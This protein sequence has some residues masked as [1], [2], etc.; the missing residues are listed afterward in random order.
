MEDLKEMM[1][2]LLDNQKTLIKN[3]D[4]LFA[5]MKEVRKDVKT[6]RVTYWK[7]MG[8]VIVTSILTVLS[9]FGIA[10]K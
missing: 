3:D 6:F 4:D 1:N 10:S 8:G 7:R 9:A 5:E 2:V